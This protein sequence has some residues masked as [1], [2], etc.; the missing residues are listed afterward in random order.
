MTGEF[1]AAL[2]W[3][4]LAAAACLT[5]AGCT[6]ATDAAA[7]RPHSTPTAS[8]S[9]T[10]CIVGTWTAG[11]TELQ[12]LYDAIPANLDYPAA[13]L[14][15]DSSLSLA[16]AADGT[17][18][19]TQDVPATLTWEGHPAAVALGGTMTG[20]Y[21]TEDG[22]MHMAATDDGLTVT[23]TDRS[24]ASS[25]F[26]LATQVTLNDWPVTATSFR[27]DGDSLALDLETEG[28]PATVE[29]ARG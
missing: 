25:L 12:P 11:A 18:T 24:Q 3:G 1:G 21:R 26:A 23:P 28:H 14:G 10:A 22:E 2:A 16:F 7:K 6:A 4:A 13:T 19:Y 17:F 15:A 27:C 5:L 29:L 8:P 20:T 9:P